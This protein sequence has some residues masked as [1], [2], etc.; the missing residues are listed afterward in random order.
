MN[1]K[2]STP[3]LGSRPINAIDFLKI[4][5]IYLSAFFI[6]S[7]A[8]AD[9][10]AA[11][12]AE[13][14]KKEEKK[15]RSATFE[16][17]MGKFDIELY[18]DEAP[19]TVENFAALAEG[20]KEFKDPKT[21]EMVKRKFYDGLIFHRIIDGFMIQGGC[22]LG[23]GRGNPGYTFK[24]EF[25]PKRRHDSPGILSMANAGPATNGSQFFITV[26]PQPRLDDKH[27]VFG[28]V[29]KGLDVVMKISKVETSGH[30]EDKPLKDVV[31]KHIKIKRK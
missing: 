23:N 14:A 26:A 1:S 17:N 28:K 21:G 31:I 29:T 24:D 11:K 3:R 5:L 15:A 16:T 2:I 30:G 20:K 13:P 19:E 12:P 18:P 22:P 10:K 7:V 6:F 27:A 8:Q 25:S 9:D 4:I